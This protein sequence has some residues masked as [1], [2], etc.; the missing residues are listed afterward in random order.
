MNH[1]WLAAEFVDAGHQHFPRLGAKLFCRPVGRLGPNSR[2]F[3]V[4]LLR[5]RKR[6]EPSFGGV[7]RNQRAATDLHRAKAPRRDFFIDFC[8]ADTVPAAKM[9]DR[10]S[11]VLL[12]IYFRTSGR[13]GESGVSASGHLSTALMFNVAR[14]GT[15]L[16]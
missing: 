15:P 12:R 3:A 2:L 5:L 8:A 4:L 11:A 10:I 9:L 7:L 6:R 13:R 1:R 14:S 16:S